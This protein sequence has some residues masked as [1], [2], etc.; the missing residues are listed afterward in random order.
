MFALTVGV[1]PEFNPKL[2]VVLVG[3]DMFEGTVVDMCAG[4]LLDAYNSC[5]DFGAVLP[6]NVSHVIG[7]GKESCCCVFGP[8][9]FFA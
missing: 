8:S 5:V 6:F 1:L 9:V 7:V 4:E 3:V 2:I